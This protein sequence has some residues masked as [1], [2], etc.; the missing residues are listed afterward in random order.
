MW[1]NYICQQ[2]DVPIRDP[3]LTAVVCPNPDCRK[4]L[5][6]S[7]GGNDDQPK[8]TM[9]PTLTKDSILFGKR[10]DGVDEVGTLPLPPEVQEAVE[11]E[12]VLKQQI[13]DLEKMD[14]TVELVTKKKQELQKLQPKLPK[15]GQ[16]LRDQVA[17]LKTLAEIEEKY[18]SK[19]Q[20]LKTSLQNLM[21]QQV[22]DVKA[23]DHKRK[24]LK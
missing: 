8:K 18:S 12:K 16:E 7:K 24:A 6:A 20:S 4:P 23:A 21:D 13:S 11:R 22:T 14:D 1:F 5:K 10:I 2:C 17:N 3:Q 19:D 15:A 9:L